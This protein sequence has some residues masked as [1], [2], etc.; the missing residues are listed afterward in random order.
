MT[1]GKIERFWKT[2]YEE[3]LVRAQ[4]GSFEEAQERI[5]HW[6]KCLGG[7]FSSAWRLRSWFLSK[8]A[9]YSS[10]NRPLMSPDRSASR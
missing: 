3:F 1:L 6:V 8:S 7:A 10:M 2:I 5:R 4:F 9:S